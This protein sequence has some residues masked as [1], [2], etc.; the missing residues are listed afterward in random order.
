[1]SRNQPTIYD[2]AK[3]AGVSIAT[4]SRV[5]NNPQLVN[6]ETRNAV[7]ST[8]DQLGFIPKS[9]A[10][11]RAMKSTRQIG[12]ITPFLT[13]QSFVQ[14]LRGV[15]SAVRARRYEL[16]VYPVESSEMLEAYINILP[17]T[18]VLDGLILLSLQLKENFAERLLRF[19][20]ETVLVEY[21]MKMLNSVAIDNIAGGRMAASYLIEKGHRSIGFVGDIQVSE[22]GIEPITHRLKGFRQE[23]SASGLSLKEEHCLYVPYDMDATRKAAYSFLQQPDRPSAI[24]AATDL[25]AIAIIRTA[26]ELGLRIPQDLAIIGFDDLDAA[27]YM[28]LTT[29]RQHLDESGRVAVE[30]LLNRLDNPNRPIQHIQLALNIVERKTT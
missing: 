21:P 3:S 8:I 28:D 26:R 22:F 10:R 2:V 20:L 18:H 6:E 15:A 14:R 30:L 11:G 24:F 13:A 7:F 16:V 17:L 1:M 19:N 23:L 4:V 9:D 27:E 5:L 25:Q 29:I 12:I